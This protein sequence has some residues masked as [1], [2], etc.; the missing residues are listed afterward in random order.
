MFGIKAQTGRESVVFQIIKAGG[1]FLG[2][3]ILGNPVVVA[4]KVSNAFI[5]L[6]LHE[7]GKGS[8][9]SRSSRKVFDFFNVF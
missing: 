2:R 1:K 4:E 9:G 3:F 6:I 5:D 7:V 8:V